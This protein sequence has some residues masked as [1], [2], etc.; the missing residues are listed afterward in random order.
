MRTKLKEMIPSNGIS[1]ID[2]AD[3]TRKIR[4][5]T[6]RV[7]KIEDVNAPRKQA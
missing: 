2:D 5:E 4:T 3:F 6:A 1:L 7:L